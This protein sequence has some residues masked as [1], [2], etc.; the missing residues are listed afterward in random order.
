MTGRTVWYVEFRPSE[1]SDWQ[2][3]R[4]FSSHSLAAH[5]AWQMQDLSR[6]SDVRLVSEHED[7]PPAGL[8]PREFQLVLEKIIGAVEQHM[9]RAPTESELRAALRRVGARVSS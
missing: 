9:G 2:R 8:D 4:P 3:S 5:A 1:A 6:T 7:G